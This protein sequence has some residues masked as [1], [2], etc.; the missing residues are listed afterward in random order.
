[1]K[2]TIQILFTLIQVFLLRLFFLVAM[3]HLVRLDGYSK[4]V[5]GRILRLAVGVTKPSLLLDVDDSMA[6]NFRNVLCKLDCVEKQ[7][8]L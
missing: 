4:L 3:V 8:K 5:L 6:L 7:S 1:M 2:S